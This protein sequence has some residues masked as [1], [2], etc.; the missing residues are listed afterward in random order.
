[1]PLKKR[2]AKST[3][4]SNVFIWTVDEVDVLLH[5]T[6]EYRGLKMAENVDWESYQK[7]YSE[8]LDLCQAR[9]L[10]SEEEHVNV[11]DYPHNP[12]EITKASYVQT[13][14]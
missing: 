11:R 10:S 12:S 5:C 3:I 7:K 14:N 9:Y 8:I 13:L 6:S 4:S 2:I 1:M